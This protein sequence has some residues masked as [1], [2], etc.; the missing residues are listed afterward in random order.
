MLGKAFATM[1]LTTFLRHRTKM[2]QYLRRVARPLCAL[3]LAV[4]ALTA[5]TLW[6]SDPA[7]AQSAPAPGAAGQRAVEPSQMAVAPPRP[8]TL[9]LA[10]GW[11]AEAL[12]A[13]AYRLEASASP[14][15]AAGHYRLLLERFPASPLATVARE[16]L[17]IL[18]A[19]PG[20]AQPYQIGDFACTAV[21]LYPGKARWCGIVRERR[22]DQLLVE[23]AEIR[24][25]T[26]FALGF[27]A[28]V[29][30]GQRFIGYFSHGDRVWIPST[31]L[32]QP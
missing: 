8:G 25:D 5:P 7:A 9:G 32:E 13:E 27:N 15:D 1:A 28:S 10:D 24:L 11:T 21:G 18:P 6:R 17:A 22:T 12:F 16:R 30:T 26:L 29:C 19:P 2:G 3:A 4:V 31:C 14:G 23:V 20:P